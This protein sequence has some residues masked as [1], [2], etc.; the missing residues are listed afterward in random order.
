V[1]LKKRIAE[2]VDD[3]EDDRPVAFQSKSGLLRRR[4][5]VAQPAGK[6]ASKS[7]DAAIA[8]IREHGTARQLKGWMR[9]RA[10][11]QM[12]KTGQV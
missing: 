6:V 12:Q 10:D 3:Q 5:L 7:E 11:L 2:T 8:E 9:H 1:T 4:R